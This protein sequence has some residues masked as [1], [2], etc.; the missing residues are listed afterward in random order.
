MKSMTGPSRIIRQLAITRHS[1]IE[2]RGS[3]PYNNA[4][5]VNPIQSFQ[6]FIDDDQSIVD[7]VCMVRRESEYS[8]VT[9][10]VLVL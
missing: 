5:L 3:A 6:D 2:E 8:N 9:F 10:N 4:D 7:Q 1:D